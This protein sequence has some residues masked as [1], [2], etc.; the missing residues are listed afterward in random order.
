MT[1]IITASAV[2]VLS[3]AAFIKLSII[4]ENDRNDNRRALRFFVSMAVFMVCDLA[5]AFI[6][7]EGGM[8]RIINTSVISNFIFLLA[9]IDFRHRVIPNL[10][11]AGALV[12]RTL[13]I[14]VQG[15]AEHA[16]LSVFVRSAVGLAAGFIILGIVAVISGKGLGAGDVK[17]F[18]VIGYF[19]GL[20]GVVDVLVYSTLFCA[21]CGIILIISK[22]C[23]VKDC[24]PMAPFAF[25]GMLLYIFTGM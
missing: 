25:A 18:A 17:M 23:G 24:I 2:A 12:L 5:S 19:L 22:K 1:G 20:Y 13:L 14:L 8:F 3:A 10:Y 15:I 7:K 4:R 11:I 9:V 21:V 16:I 6:V